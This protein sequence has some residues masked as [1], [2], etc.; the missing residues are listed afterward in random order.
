MFSYRALL[1]FDSEPA[2]LF[3]WL[4][5]RTERSADPRNVVTLKALFHIHSTLLSL[6]WMQWGL[7]S[8]GTPFTPVIS[9]DR[10]T[11]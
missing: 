11:V 10:T 8:I 3:R 1:G 5:H 2:G 4:A 7:R 6:Y 9:A